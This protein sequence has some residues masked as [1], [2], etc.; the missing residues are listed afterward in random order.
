MSLFNALETLP[1]VKRKADWAFKWMNRFESKYIVPEKCFQNVLLI[2]KFHIFV[3]SIFVT[4]ITA[5]F[6]SPFPHSQKRRD[7][8]VRHLTELL[9]NHYVW[10]YLSIYRDNANFAERIIAFASVEGIFFSGSF[11]SIFWL[12]KRL[13]FNCK[14]FVDKFKF[15]H[16]TEVLH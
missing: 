9:L 4:P 15:G 8:E 7:W 13:V 14:V 5:D 3:C 12:K 11:A 16:S 2:F 6:R 10:Y 1:C